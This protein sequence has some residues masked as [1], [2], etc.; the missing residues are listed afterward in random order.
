M[1][2]SLKQ[3]TNFPED[4]FD[5][6]C[7]SPY[8]YGFMNVL[9]TEG[10]KEQ[11]ALDYLMKL[12]QNGPFKGKVFLAGGAVRDMELGKDPKDLDV[13]VTGGIDAGM[14]FA[15]WAAQSMG[16]YKEGS[17]PVLY[18]T[19]G[20]AKFTM[21]GIT[22]NGIDL[23]DID[24][25][26]VATRK[27]KYTTGSRK[28]EVSAG[29]LED[30]VQ[31]R[32]FTVNS[33]LKDLT[34]GEILDLTG[35]GREDIKS[36]II[37]T[38]LNPDI[39]FTDD[40]LRMLRAIRFAVKYNWNL[41]MFMIKGL[42]KNASKLPNISAERIRDELNKMLVTGSPDRAI[43]LLKVTGL[44]QYVIP[45]LLPA[46]KM[47]Q[48]VHHKHDVFDHTLDVLRNSRPDL[49]ERLMALFHDIGKTVTKS[50][51][52]TGVH[53]YGH[54]E[55][56]EKMTDEIMKRLKYPNELID[57][58]KLGVRHHMRLK[59]AGD[60]GVNISDKALRKFK[61]DMGNQLESTLNLMHADN[62]AHSEASSMPNQIDN[63]RKRLNALDVNLTAG[64]PKLPVNGNDLMQLGIK[65]GP[66]FT[67]IL[68]QITDAWYD[69][70]KLSR[71][72]AL[73]IARNV[74]GI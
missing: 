23:S 67:D 74:A 54:E 25:E 59:S 68:K 19:F 73:G 16:N 47:M 28:P 26:S 30:D 22:H 48:N 12:V 11:T 34:T 62:I 13:V 58:V 41:P 20:T 31:R 37:R 29:D 9:M 43:K 4:V 64:K 56:S 2:P 60:T 51:T 44:L 17:N 72:E 52:P 53:F 42:R 49:V 21:Q 24:V 10:V 14:N 57:A 46:V 7:L 63:I 35:K 8:D 65:P 33:L 70:P 36:G 71:E 27:E 61:V 55:A 50:V 38:P 69:N 15:K 6:C 32:D 45:E 1:I 18:P 66:I 5:K 3:L 40:P 39:I